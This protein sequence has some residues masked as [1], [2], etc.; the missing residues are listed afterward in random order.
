MEGEVVFAHVFCNA[1]GHATMD[2]T[3]GYDEG[4]GIVS[5]Y[6][7]EGKCEGE[8]QVFVDD[9]TNAQFELLQEVRRD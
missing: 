1:C 9:L 4:S 5:I 3:W 2:P 6:C 7:G 8:E